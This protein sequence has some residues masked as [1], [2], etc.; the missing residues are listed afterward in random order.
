MIPYLTV[1]SASTLNIVLTWYWCNISSDL[2]LTTHEY[3]FQ[4]GNDVLTT[5]KPHCFYPWYSFA[6]LKLYKCLQC[7]TLEIS[8]ILKFH[9]QKVERSFVSECT[10]LCKADKTRLA[11]SAG[12]RK[13][14]EFP[15][16]IEPSSHRDSKMS[17]SVAQWQSIGG[18]NPKGTQNFFLSNARD[19][20][21]KQLCSYFKFKTYSLKFMAVL[22]TLVLL[23]QRESLI[24]TYM[25]KTTCFSP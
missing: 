12:Q 11:T 10:F 13:N 15:W 8:T 16:G 21:R 20:T 14:S 22:S 18:Q 19:K 4:V 24:S 7:L 2:F 25:F 17:I 5:T 3:N 1:Q 6:K 23:K 9:E